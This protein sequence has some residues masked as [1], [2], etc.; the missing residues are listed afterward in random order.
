[1]YE[2]TDNLFCT[3]LFTGGLATKKRAVDFYKKGISE[4]ETGLQISCDGEGTCTVHVQC[5]CAVL[6]YVAKYNL[7]AGRP[8]SFFFQ[9]HFTLLHEEARISDIRFTH[10]LPALN[11]HM[12]A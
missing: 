8:G 5:T 2:I 12:V 4:L 6:F 10:F 3:V 7:G 9:W 1:M 11:K